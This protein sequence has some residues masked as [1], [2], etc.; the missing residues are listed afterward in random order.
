M[1][2][3]PIL[4]YALFLISK[5][6][7]ASCRPALAVASQQA[8]VHSSTSTLELKRAVTKYRD[9]FEKLTDKSLATKMASW[10][11]DTIKKKGYLPGLKGAPGEPKDLEGVIEQGPTVWINIHG[12]TV[13]VLTNYAYLMTQGETFEGPPEDF[14]YGAMIVREFTRRMIKNGWTLSRLIKSDKTAES[15]V[16]T[17]ANFPN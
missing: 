7:P 3:K 15:E 16:N 2:Q 9:M 12:N 17:I 14:I 11:Q 8:A 10:I 1:F 6:V 13:G 4:F 5:E